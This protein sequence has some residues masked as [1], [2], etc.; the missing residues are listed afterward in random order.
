MSTLET[1]NLAFKLQLESNRREIFE[2]RA[3]ELEGIND[4]L[5]IE[6]DVRGSAN[7]KV[8]P[9]QNST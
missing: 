1:E 5:R 9:S 4:A 3:A 8:I 6:N 7:C 2:R